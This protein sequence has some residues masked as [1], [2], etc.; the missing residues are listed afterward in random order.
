MACGCSNQGPI[1]RMYTVS[2]LGRRNSR[3]NGVGS[4]SSYYNILYAFYLPPITYIYFLFS[5]SLHPALVFT[6]SVGA[7]VFV[8]VGSI[9]NVVLGAERL[10]RAQNFISSPAVSLFFFSSTFISFYIQRMIVSLLILS[11]VLSP[12]CRAS[13]SLNAIR[14]QSTA[15]RFLAIPR[16]WWEAQAPF[17][18]DSLQFLRFHT[19]TYSAY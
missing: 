1:I 11:L 15:K 14:Q 12:L 17:F 16:S 4:A 19:S 2:V 3:R 6:A 5:L 8:R 9:E 18:A 13:Y 7:C 10:L